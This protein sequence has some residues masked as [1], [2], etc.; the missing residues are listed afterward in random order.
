[1]GVSQHSS[2]C[3]SLWDS[4]LIRFSTFP[5]YDCAYFC[6]PK[7]SFLSFVM[8]SCK[9]ESFLNDKR[10][11]LSLL[12]NI[13]FNS[14]NSCHL[15]CMILLL[16]YANFFHV[17]SWVNFLEKVVFFIFENKKLSCFCYRPIGTLNFFWC[18]RL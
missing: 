16:V 7:K 14:F 8:C 15:S 3:K 13:G 9:T 11:R 2:H 6:K 1:M 5:N 10:Y 12:F 17:I 4:E 18:F